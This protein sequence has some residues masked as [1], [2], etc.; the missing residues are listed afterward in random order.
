MLPA[1]LHLHHQQYQE[2]LPFWIFRTE[3]KDPVLEL[4]CGSGRVTLPLLEAGRTVVGIDRERPHLDLLTRQLE[5]HP[6][7]LRERL[8]LVEMDLHHFS[9]PGCFGAVILPCN[10]F[11]SFPPR[12]R[13]SLT[14]R[15]YQTL[16]PG[17]IFLVSLPNPGQLA[18]VHQQLLRDPEAGIE[19]IEGEFP[20]P[21][22][23]YPVQVASQLS[24]GPQGVVWC[25]HYDHLFPDGRVK[26]A[27]AC[28]EQF[29]FSRRELQ[30]EIRAAGLRLVEVCGDF[31]GRR[32]RPG[33]PHLIL[34]AEKRS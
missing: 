29:L 28:T 5:D 33:S 24:P 32:F 6:P 13:Q 27:S 16:K 17:G 3:G 8:L 2:D 34:Q 23:G 12:A 11:S 26:R 31:D 15:I 14:Q 9:C 22:T 19:A 18:A 30:G 4:G 21:E 25:W 7:A 20:H 10:T 1:Y